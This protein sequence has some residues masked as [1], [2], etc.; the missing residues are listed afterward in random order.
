M[1]L[2]FS[3]PH[4]DIGVDVLGPRIVI[5]PMDLLCHG[6]VLMKAAVDSGVAIRSSL[7]YEL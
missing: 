6:G 4:E 2:A 7:S 5:W 1:S 3:D